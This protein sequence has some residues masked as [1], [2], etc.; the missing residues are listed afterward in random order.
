VDDETTGSNEILEVDVNSNNTSRLLLVWQI[1]SVTTMAAMITINMM[2]HPELS[3]AIDLPAVDLW[4]L[5]IP[6]PLPASLDLRYF[7]SGGLCAAASHGITTPMDVIKTKLQSSPW[8]YKGQSLPQAAASIIQQEGPQCLLQGLAPTV[9]GYGLEGALKF[10]LYESLKPTIV[11]M[12]VAWTSTGTEDMQ[13]QAFLLA[14]IAA[15]A[16]AS[17]VLCPMEQTRIRMVTDP[18]FA[19]GFVGGIA[20]L[21]QEEGPSAIFYGFPAMLSKQVPYVRSL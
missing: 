13:T 2:I 3:W 6:D 19:D 14:S 7:V 11:S 4:H 8:Q 1:L 17:I 15:G 18:Q 10:G 21:A 16:V 5:Q 12:L 9:V 20:R